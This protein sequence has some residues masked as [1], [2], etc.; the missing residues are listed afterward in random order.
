M[1]ESLFRYLP[2]EYATSFIKRGEVLFRSLSYYRDYE[3]DNIRRDEFEGTKVHLPHDGLKLTKIESGE[4]VSLPHR[5]ESTANEDEIFVYCL[6]ALCNESLAKD[7]KTKTCIEIVKPMIFIGLI[8]NAIERRSSIKNKQLTH[9]LVNYYLPSDPP[10]GDWALPEKIALSKLSLPSF[11]R[12][13]E[14]RIA[15]AVNRA[16][17]VYNVNTKLVLQNEQRDKNKYKNYPEKVFKLGDLSKIC[18]VH[19]F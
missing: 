3:D 18:K 8:R 15:F 14:Y 17:D 5:F 13:K 11:T 19:R 16:F 6:S 4:V 7:F 12:Q 10:L 2:E 9:G 1:K